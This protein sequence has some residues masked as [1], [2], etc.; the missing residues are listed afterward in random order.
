MSIGYSATWNNYPEDY[1]QRI[2][3]IPAL[4][5][6]CVAEEVGEYGTPHLQFECI[7]QR[8]ISL[9]TLQTKCPGMA[10]MK[11]WSK[12]KSV[13]G[14]REY[15]DPSIA[16]TYTS[17]KDN[18]KKGDL[19]DKSQSKNY[20]EWGEAPVTFR[21]NVIAAA[22]SGITKRKWI[23]TNSEYYMQ[24]HQAVDK[25]WA[26]FAQ[27]V[28]LPVYPSS[29]YKIPLFDLSKKPLLLYDDRK[30]WFGKTNFAFAHFPK[31]YFKINS[32]HQ[33]PDF[34]PEIHTG[35]VADDVKWHKEDIEDI[36]AFVDMEED[37]KFSGAKYIRVFEIPK[38][39]KKIICANHHPFKG[40]DYG[41]ICK[42]IQ[43]YHVTE[44]LSDKIPDE[45]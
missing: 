4:R 35:I 43:V 2:P 26:M 17:D 44:K 45:Q 11:P 16:F 10:N 42:R 14:A 30:G 13:K 15:V 36:R 29:D 33:L 24:K 19:K 39:T 37:Q 38:G 9:K 31:G 21:V 25:V 18:H 6:F 3:T 5:W 32:F 1:R 41:P 22:R 40:E 7:V 12:H 27:P 28:K 8:P 34:D 23:E 20:W